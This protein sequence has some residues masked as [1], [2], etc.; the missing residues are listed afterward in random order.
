MF[1]VKRVLTIFLTE[2]ESKNTMAEANPSNGYFS[3]GLQTLKV[4]VQLFA[5]NRRRLC[6]Q[7]RTLDNV[8]DGSVILL[9][10]HETVF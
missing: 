5:E 7:L 1:S 3:M 9:Q 10:V 6:E 8:G 4:P 2:S